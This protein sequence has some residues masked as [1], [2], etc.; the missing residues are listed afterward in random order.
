MI[1]G[2]ESEAISQDAF[3]ICAIENEILQKTQVILLYS[4]SLTFMHR[5]NDGL[6]HASQVAFNLIPPAPIAITKPKNMPI[7]EVGRLRVV[8][9]D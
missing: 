6:D 5:M 1:L 7:Q 2:H 4:G 3:V 9:N 8:A